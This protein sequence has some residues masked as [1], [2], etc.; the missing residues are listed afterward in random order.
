MKEFDP[1]ADLENDLF[2]RTTNLNVPALLAIGGWT[3]S[4][5]DKYSRLAANPTARSNFIRQAVTFLKKYN[6]SGLMFDWNYPK[7]WQSNCKKGPSYDK[8]NFAAFMQELSAEFRRQDPPLRLGVSLSGYAEVIREAYDLRSLSESADFMPVMTY[9]YHGAWEGKTGHVSPLYAKP[10]DRFPQYNVDYTLQELVKLGAHREK[11]IMGIPFYGQTFTLKEHSRGS[12]ILEGVE[13]SGAGNAGEF[14][15]QPGMMAYYEICDRIR[16]QKWQSGRDA[17]EKSGPFA[18]RDTQW[19]GYD[20]PK[21]IAVK[22]KYVKDQGFGGIMAWTVDLDDYMNRCC[23]ES[24]PL[25]KAINRGLGRLTSQAPVSGDCTRPPTPVTPVPPVMTTVGEGG[26]DSMHHHTEWPSYTSTSS[27]GATEQTTSSA[28]WTTTTRFTTRATTT[29]AAPTT[30]ATVIPPPVN[31]MPMPHPDH[32]KCEGHEHIPNEKDCSS[33]Y[34]CSQGEFIL[35]QCAAGLHWNQVNNVCDW[36]A[37]AKCTHDLIVQS[38]TQRTTAWTTSWTTPTITTRFT[39]PPKRTTTPTTTTQVQFITHPTEKPSSAPPCISGQYY[40]HKDCS[41]YYICVN[42]KRV[43]Q[44]CPPGLQ[45]QY[46]AS[47]C[48]W[49]DKVKCM[50]VRE[51]LKKLGSSL[52]VLQEGDVCADGSYAPYPGDCTQY[53]RCIHN[54]YDIMQCADGLHWND[55]LKNCDW[56]KRSGC[57]DSKP[58][59]K[60]TGSPDHREPQRPDKEE[61]KPQTQPLDGETVPES[62]ELK[63]FSGYYKMVCYFTNWAWYRKGAGKYVPEDIDTNLCTHVIYGFAVLDYSNLVLRTHDSWADIDNKFYE[64]VSGLKKK[65]VKVS[66]ALGGWNDSQ[67][68]KYSRLVRSPASRKKFIDHA[69]L[70]IEKY[71]FEGLDLDWEYPVCWQVDCKKGFPDEKQ[72]F[73]DL[74]R[75]LSEAFKPKGYLLSTAVSPSKMVVDAGYDVPTLAKYFD[76]IAVMTYDFHGQWDKQTGHVA[77]LYYHPEDEVPHFNSN[78]SLHYW[79]EKGAPARKIVMGMPLYGQS[80]TLA[81]AKNNGLNAKAPGPGQ[82]GE[83]TKAAGFLAYYEICDRIKNRG[84]RVVKD[85]QGRMG[86]YA[87]HGNQWVSFDDQETLKRKTQLVR[88]MDLGGGMIWALDLDDFKN[89]CGQGKHPLLTVIREGLRD[90]PAGKEPAPEPTTTA[91]P[92]VPSVD[93]RVDEVIQEPKPPAQEQPAHYTEETSDSG[94]DSG[95]ISNEVH[96]DFKVV[97]YFTNWAWYRQGGGKFVPEDIDPELC[98]HIVYGFAVLNR[99]TLTIQP[100]DSWADMDNRFYERVVAFK[101]KGVKVTVAI[102]GWNDSAGDKYSRLVLSPSARSKFVRHVREFIEKYGFDGLDLDWEYPVC[103]QVDC[104]KGSANEKEGFVALVGELSREFK[105]RGLLLSSAVSPSKKVVDEG[106][107]VAALSQLFDWIAVM[108]YDFH[109]QWDKQTGHVAPMYYHPLDVESTFNANFSINYWLQKGADAKK[110]VMGMPM[111]GQSFSLAEGNRH[112][113]NSPTYGGGEAGEATRARGFLAY[114]EICSNIRQRNWRVVRDKKGRMGPY[115]YNRDQWVSFD[116][117]AMIRHKSEY[118]K[119]MGLGGAM[120]WALDLDDFRNICGC[121]EYPLLRTINRVLRGYSTPAPNCVLET[122]TEYE[123]DDKRPQTSTTTTTTERV[124]TK[125]T[126]PTPPKR[127][128]TAA[129]EAEKPAQEEPES[130]QSEGETLENRSCSGDALMAHESDCNKYYICQFGHYA[131]QRCPM[132]LHWNRD[133]CDWPD[134]AK[135]EPSSGSTTKRPLATRK[136]TTQPSSTTEITPEIVTEKTTLKPESRPELPP[137]SAPQDPGAMKVV[138][139]FTNWAWYRPGEGKYTPD[140]ID[141]SL[142]THIVYGFAVLNR[143]TLT[144]KTHDSWADID[145][146]FY[147]RVVEYKRKG[148]KVTVA[149]GGWNDSLGDKYSRL[150][151]SPQARANFVRN[152]AE[153]IEKY[154]FD[155]LD[156]DWEYPVCWQVE[157]DKGYPDEKQGFAEL[158]KELAQEFRPRGWLLS[159]AVSP[160]KM[161]IDKG[162]D[163]PTLADYFDWIAVMTYDFHGHWDK[164]TGHVAPLYYYP[165]DTYDYFNANFSIN[166]WIEKG[167]PPS[168][169]VMGLPLYGQSFSLAD[170]GKRGVNEKSYGPG[171]AGEFTRAGGFLAYYEICQRTN[172]GGWTVVRDPQGRI[173]PYA[174]KGS[175]WVSYDDVSEVRRKAQFIREMKLGGGMIWALDLDDFRGRCGCGKH[176]LLRTLN[177]EL[178]AIS[179]QR[180]NDCT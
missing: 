166:Y 17:A 11:L 118:V 86:P 59:D 89:R 95:E 158:V 138:C 48:D 100:H 153:F 136:T 114:Y 6:F 32:R 27:T 69:L 105:P 117:V 9:D 98:T 78:F 71:G 84:W 97:C 133:H 137:I 178:R 113:L 36:P 124:T 171:E 65:G 82:A 176:P 12:I 96:G 125:R 63:P 155:G 39:S 85:E 16:K 75:E 130:E 34:R 79:I 144:I 73:S 140:D 58:A 18:W 146:R 172:N 37:N 119:A 54:R 62:S 61:E 165:G 160:S 112:G 2:R 93:N 110:I 142:C 111:Y 116:D 91:K 128:S 151:R 45:Y 41:M 180:A 46:Q 19:V 169:L 147:E 88:S 106:Y 168:K 22:T 47:S 131:I 52:K 90:P 81:D 157:C 76:W 15:R 94:L 5:G 108:T 148:I 43:I 42:G 134:A 177:Q 163:V 20:D 150:V 44:S 103:W 30:A 77:P 173:G 7:C 101:K 28:W 29:T 3:D 161:V 67:G 115:A 87:Y 92:I 132:N 70:F 26:V 135:C 121:E 57:K 51:Y 156:L 104:N 53:L 127:T 154:G 179:G 143:D 66:L 25:L 31:V 80:F 139:Y 50:S 141:A 60:P 167:A 38:T 145:N 21:S 55:N 14:T 99:E 40:P 68:D 120:I 24:F 174:Y 175:Q 33:Y 129:P 149:I 102:G 126:T 4:A 123:E 13:T 10:N 64:R 56:P 107:E 1:W 159:S 8:S 23:H 109:G 72:G 170:A 122:Q 35:Q 49:A 164:Q 83:F 74:V 152:V 162:Y